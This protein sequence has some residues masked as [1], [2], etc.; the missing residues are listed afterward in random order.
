[1]PNVLYDLVGP[2]NVDGLIIWASA[3]DWE[4][5]AEQ[6]EAFCRRFAPLPV[7]TVGRLFEGLPSV[8][9]DNYQGMR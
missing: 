4:L 5:S 2:A 9:V 1:M 6:M 8:L 7:V 3:L